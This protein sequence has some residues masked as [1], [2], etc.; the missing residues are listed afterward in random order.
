MKIE[1]DGNIF[2]EVRDVHEAVGWGA[3]APTD[4]AF[5]GAVIILMLGFLRDVLLEEFLG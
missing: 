3:G 1:G 4:Y 5:F 2:I